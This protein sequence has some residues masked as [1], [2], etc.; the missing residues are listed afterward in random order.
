MVALSRYHL[1][2]SVAGTAA[3]SF[4]GGPLFIEVTEAKVHD[5]QTLVV[6][7]QKILRLQ[8]AVADAHSVDVVDSSDELLE[9]LAGLV[10]FELLVADDVVE[11]LA[12]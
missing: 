10:L 12:A 4:Q 5:L 11:E 7:E 2:R 3:S 6:V 8:V 1:R 9:D